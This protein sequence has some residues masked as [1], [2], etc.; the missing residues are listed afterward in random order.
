MRAGRMDRLVTLK[1]RTA[2]TQDSYGEET[3]TFESVQVW[4][5][6][7]EFTGSEAF[8]GDRFIAGQ[9]AKYR[10]YY[11]EDLDSMD[12]LVDGSSTFNIHAVIPIGRREGLELMVTRKE[13]D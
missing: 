13:E 5:E 8:Q 3:E 11:R 7:R 1:I 2:G 4:A 6:R 12:S 10:I 9:A